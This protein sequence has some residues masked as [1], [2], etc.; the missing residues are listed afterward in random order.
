M[1]PGRR[2][3]RWRGDSGSG[4]VLDCDESIRRRWQG[5]I[6]SQAEPGRAEIRMKDPDYGDA[7]MGELGKVL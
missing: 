6:L 5:R 2:R 4:R 3:P 7:V 1:F